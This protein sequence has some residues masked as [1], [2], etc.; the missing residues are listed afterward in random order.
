[1]AKSKKN[2]VNVVYSTNPDFSYD[3]EDNEEEETLPPGQQ[4]LRVWLDK[5]NRAGKEASIVRGFIG[6]TDDLKALGN[7]I[8][9]ACGTGGSVKDVEIIIQGDKRDTII[10]LLTKEGYKAKK[11]GA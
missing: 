6:S 7:E 3:D 1:M 10:K 11:A 4:D 2:R 8:K 9:Q 5:K